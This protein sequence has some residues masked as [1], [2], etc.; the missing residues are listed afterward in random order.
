LCI[1]TYRR[2]GLMVEADMAAREFEK[3]RGQL[4]LALKGADDV[5]ADG[6]VDAEGEEDVDADGD[7]DVVG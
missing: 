4:P 5:D 2:N 3:V 1:N 6:D 7:V